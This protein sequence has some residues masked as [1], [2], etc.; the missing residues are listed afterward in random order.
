[1]HQTTLRIPAKAN[2]FFL[3][4]HQEFPPSAEEE[5]FINISDDEE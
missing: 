4:E 1:M 3:T 5:D 2:V